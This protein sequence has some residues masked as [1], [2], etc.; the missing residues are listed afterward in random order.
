MLLKIE[1]KIE[2]RLANHILLTQNERDEQ[3]SNTTISIE[4]RVNR[5]ELNVVDGGLEEC[6]SKIIIMN[7]LFEL[8]H[9]RLNLGQRRRYKRAFPGLVPP[10]QF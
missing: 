7:K 4:K 10:I 3:A 5:L 2:Q 9:A 1:Q 6:P 8:C